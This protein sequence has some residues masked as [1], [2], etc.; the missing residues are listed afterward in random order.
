MGGSEYGVR[1]MA[2]NMIVYQQIR[3]DAVKEDAA[4]MHVVVH[5][6]VRTLRIIQADRA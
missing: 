5:E 2:I 4:L 3:N 1:A 6:T